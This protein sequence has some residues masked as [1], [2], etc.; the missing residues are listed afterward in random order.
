MLP[1]GQSVSMAVVPRKWGG[2]T[3]NQ[4]CNSNPSNPTLHST[5]APWTLAMWAM[6]KPLP[7]LVVSMVVGSPPRLW[8]LS[9]AALARGGGKL[10]QFI[11]PNVQHNMA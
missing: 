8:G 1:T 6:R 10:I 11:L 4:P 5:L 7:N 9:K 2:V 3:R